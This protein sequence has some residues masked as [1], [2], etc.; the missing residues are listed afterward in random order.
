MIIAAAA[1]GLWFFTHVGMLLLVG[2]VALFRLF[3]NDAP[4]QS[5]PSILIEF[6]GLL[7]VLG[8]VASL[9]V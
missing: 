1:A 4:Q 6:L 7:G 2:G 8:F 3:S 5:N 9:P